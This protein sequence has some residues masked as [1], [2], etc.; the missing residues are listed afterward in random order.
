MVSP[1]AQVVAFTRSEA[2]RDRRSGRIRRFLGRG[3]YADG[4]QLDGHGFPDLG[5]VGIE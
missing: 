3:L 5:F 1:S 4:D 2:C